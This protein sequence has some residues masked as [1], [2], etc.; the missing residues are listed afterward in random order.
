MDN[1]EKQRLEEKRRFEL[2]QKKRDQEYFSSE[3]KKLFEKTKREVEE[4]SQLNLNQ[5]KKMYK[6]H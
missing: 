1:P 5:C 4:G 3:S 2:R 6:K